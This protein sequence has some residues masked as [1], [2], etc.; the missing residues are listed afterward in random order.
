MSI[1]V[2]A[3][4]CDDIRTEIGNK[5][6]Y[7]GVYLSEM[8]IQHIPHTLNFRAAVYIRMPIDKIADEVILKFYMND[9]EIYS[10]DLQGPLKDEVPKLPDLGLPYQH[11]SLI[12]VV[13]FPF[14]EFKEDSILRPLAITKD[15]KYWGTP[16][17]IRHMPATQEDFN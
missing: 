8:W 14:I 2:L 9:K 7:M 3:I 13:H 10:N 4:Y 17:R 12:S 1:E 11:H 5:L 15:G 6:S 16:L